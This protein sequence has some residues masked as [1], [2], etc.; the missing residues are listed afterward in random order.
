MTEKK[1]RPQLV[2]HVY[3]P[4]KL[5]HYFSNGVVYLRK[6]SAQAV[7]DHSVPVKVNLDQLHSLF[8]HR[9]Q[10]NSLQHLL[11]SQAKIK[12]FE[13]KNKCFYAL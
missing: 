13:G 4:E 7:S 10:T 1:V 11:G 6:V 3:I 2:V 12:T 9:C 8:L 5:Q